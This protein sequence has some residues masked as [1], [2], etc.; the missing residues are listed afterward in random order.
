MYSRAN[1]KEHVPLELISNPVASKKYDGAHYFMQVGPTGSIRFISRRES[2][3]GGFPDRTEKVPHLV[4]SPLPQY[5]GNVYNVELIHSGNSKSNKESHA[6]VSGILNSLAPK[7]I[8]T[9]ALTG[10][11][12][13]VLLDVV[14][15]ALSTFQDK[16]SHLK[17]VEKA[18]NKPDLIFAP[19]FVT[20]SS[21]IEEE[22]KRTKASGEEGVV[23]TSLT[24]PE[25]SNF[26]VKIKHKNTYNLK[27]VGITQEVD[28]NGIPKQ[29]AGALVV[30]DSTNRV[31][32][33]V[34]TGFTK[35]LRKEIFDNQP[36]WMDAIIQV[37]AMDSTK[38]VDGK[39]RM[40]VY[41]GLGD[42]EIDK[43]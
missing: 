17:E 22:I 34:G 24:T 8:E 28:K 31:V 38:A 15:P 3:K 33:S 41:N 14:H 27:V 16:A 5:A 1:Y 2:V 35:E 30:A 4:T 23:I 42:G 9:Q 32:G 20:G 37:V 18:L 39:L 10:P 19:V 29:S 25:S 40:P 7:A 43:V 11:V 26:R 36:K 13:A 6:A 12:R 21:K